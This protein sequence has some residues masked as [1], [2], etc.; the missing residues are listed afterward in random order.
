MDF[1]EWI[2]SE[3]RAVF[4]QILQDR[5]CKAVPT[6]AA[7]LLRY[8]AQMEFIQQIKNFRLNEKEEKPQEIR[9][10]LTKAGMWNR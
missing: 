7:N 4:A 5:L 1:E 10:D 6:D 2:N 3:N 8:G 9:R